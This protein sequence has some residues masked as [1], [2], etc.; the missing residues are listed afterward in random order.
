MKTKYALLFLALL[1]TLPAM[2][3]QTTKISGYMFGDAY[4]IASAPDADLEGRSAFQYRRIYV[5]LDKGIAENVDARFRIEA[6]QPGDF[7][8]KAKM[9]PFVKDAY[10]RW[11]RSGHSVYFGLST[12]PT[13]SRLESAWGLRSVEKTP[14]D[15]YK[16]G[17]SRDFG[18]AAK[19]PLGSS[20]RISYHA[21]LANGASTGS[22]TNDGKKALLSLAFEVVDGLTFEAYG[23]YEGRD[24]D[25]DRSTLQGSLLYGGDWGRIGATFARQTRGVE[26][27]DAT[28][29]DV[30]S[31]YLAAA[32]SDRSDAFV[33]VDRQFDP[34][35]SA[36]KISY[37][38]FAMA[39]AT[40]FVVAGVSVEVVDKVF[41]QPNVE[42]VT[43]SVDSGDAPNSTVI[44]RMTV[45]FKF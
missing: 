42:L 18:I 29:L 11:K 28:T 5:T 10:I 34:N 12:T 17:S 45:F 4:Y 7:A 15:L 8:T 38:P 39:D 22:E 27:A 30:A 40:T 35:P 37:L 16:F 36:A 33:R 26:G 21:M 24:G 13:W 32:V 2:A 31:V 44:P 3:Q 41:L 20:G 6:S 19:G 1:I 14:L 9:V 23:D 43:Y 25:T